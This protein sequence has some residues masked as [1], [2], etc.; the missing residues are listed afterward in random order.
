MADDGLPSWAEAEAAGLRRQRKAGA[1]DLTKHRPAGCLLA[2]LILVFIFI[3][4]VVVLTVFGGDPRAR[5]VRHASSW[6]TVGSTAGSQVSGVRATGD[7]A[8]NDLPTAHVRQPTN[9]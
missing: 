8:R 6:L 4:A 2:F 5:P 1:D 7:V 3:V 9:A